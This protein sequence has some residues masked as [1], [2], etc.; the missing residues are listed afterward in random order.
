MSTRPAFLDHGA[1]NTGDNIRA[2]IAGAVIAVV[3]ATAITLI[4]LVV[5]A[6]QT[7]DD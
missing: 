5:R 6:A 4:I 3:L 7:R 1:V 2:C